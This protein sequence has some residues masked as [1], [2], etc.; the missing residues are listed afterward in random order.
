MAE[1]I[2]NIQ[3]PVEEVNEQKQQDEKCKLYKLYFDKW[4]AG[5][6]SD[7]ASIE[8]YNDQTQI[9]ESSRITTKTAQ[10]SV[11]TLL[12]VG[13]VSVFEREDIYLIKG[14]P[15]SGKSTLCKV[16]IASTILGECCSIKAEQTD[17]KVAYIDTEQKFADTQGM[18]NYVRKQTDGKVSNDYIDAHFHLFYLRK[19]DYTQLKR[20]LLRIIIDYRPDIIICDGIAD[21]VRSVNDEEA[22]RE[23]ILFE[24]RIVE[25]FNC[26]IIDLIHENKSRDDHNPKGH[27]GQHGKQKSA[28]IIGTTKKGDIIKA[29]CDAS[30]HRTMPDLFLM[31]NEDGMI[32]D[33]TES[34]KSLQKAE[35]TKTVYL[36]IAQDI[37]KES[38]PISRT[39]LSKKM[40]EKTG[41]SPQWMATTITQLNGNGI[42]IIDNI[43]Q[44]V[45]INDKET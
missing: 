12:S 4:L 41:K 32:C 15:K 18:L 14:D 44:L 21:F 17:L 8:S 31:Y 20:D 16:I 42:N 2:L 38:G 36:K 5:S 11:E 33:G 30:R 29:S 9:L 7:D 34:Y 43:V 19:R 39:E 26:A 25:E 24:L 40:A 10:K 23:I 28:I 1:E 13:D 37:I 3:H 35:Q 27:L 45:Q 22:S 6:E